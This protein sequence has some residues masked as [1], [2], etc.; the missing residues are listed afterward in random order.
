LCPRF[1]AGAE[2]VVIRVNVRNRLHF[3]RNRQKPFDP[4]DTRFWILSK[5]EILKA[6]VSEVLRELAAFSD[7]A[8]SPRGFQETHSAHPFGELETK[9]N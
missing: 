1:S 7:A 4:C 3:D 6:E 9:P 5:I 2:V 8:E